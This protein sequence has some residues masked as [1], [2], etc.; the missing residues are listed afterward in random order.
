MKAAAFNAEF[1]GP[2]HAAGQSPWLFI[3]YRHLA[4][5]TFAYSIYAAL[6]NSIPAEEI[7]FDQSGIPPG[8]NYQV[9]LNRTIGGAEALIAVIGPTWL[10]KLREKRPPGTRDWVRTE[11]AVALK[12]GIK[13]I[14]VLGDGCQMPHPAELP[15]DLQQLQ[16]SQT[17]HIRGG[18][19]IAQDMKGLLEAILKIR[20]RRHPLPPPFKDRF[21]DQG[22]GR[23]RGLAAF[24]LISL[25]LAIV[26]MLPGRRDAEPVNPSQLTY[27]L[28]DNCWVLYD[29]YGM[30]L[31]D[32]R[33]EIYPH[34]DSIAIDL[35]LIQR[36]GFS[37]VCTPSCTGVMSQVPR[38]ARGR[39]LK[40][41]A[42][43]KN[44]A[45]DAELGRAIR[46]REFV[47]AYCLGSNQLGNTYSIDTLRS[48]IE[49]VKSET[50]R[51]ATTSEYASH[52]DE[53]LAGLGDW[54]F[55]DA[56]VT[57]KDT[58][59]TESEVNIERDVGV[60]MDS[61]RAVLPYAQ[62]TGRPILF[63]NVTYPHSGAK[64]ASRTAQADFFR[65]LLARL[66][67]PHR[68]HPVRTG[69]VV[70]SVFDCPWKVGKPFEAWDPHSGLLAVD[71]SRVATAA[72]VQALNTETLRSLALQ[73]ILKWHP[74][75]T[76]SR[77]PR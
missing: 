43:V 47:D 62:K 77:N 3:S 38:L 42:S 50:N 26:A 32:D 74:R 52:Y 8:E 31:D 5:G 1:D 33:V 44:P 68:G 36:A 53:E 60:M 20:A 4:D 2:D 21:W 37:G 65:T 39:G 24:A 59:A 63:R 61:T 71:R 29:P 25:L 67:D 54:L 28:N 41:I 56:H 58:P 72:D 40:V 46:L 9:T 75:L 34:I 12:R 23:L 14:P 18:N 35:D 66:N 51:P 13:V 57:V 64:G 11:I 49:R 73:E 27:L 7:F 22:P 55:P 76:A 10:E 70:H 15:E 6:L 45:D 19:Y 48:A 69:I 17:F 16:F 30:E